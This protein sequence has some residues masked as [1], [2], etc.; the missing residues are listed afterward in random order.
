MIMLFRSGFISFREYY[1][2]LADVTTPFKAKAKI[3]RCSGGCD[4]IVKYLTHAKIGLSESLLALIKKLYP[5][6]QP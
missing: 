5:T 1:F 2:G 6:C 3:A 4:L